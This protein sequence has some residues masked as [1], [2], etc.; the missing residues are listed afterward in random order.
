MSFSELKK[1]SKIQAKLCQFDHLFIA[2]LL[3]I[4][5]YI[6]HCSSRLLLAIF[7]LNYNH[8]STSSLTYTLLKNCSYCFTFHFI[9][10]FYSFLLF[11]IITPVEIWHITELRNKIYN[12]CLLI[13][14]SPIVLLNLEIHF[15]S[16]PYLVYLALGQHIA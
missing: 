15:D 7:F 6:L 11:E 3:L 13:K 2:S 10:N 8:L 4:L 9:H 16:F 12:S 1:A 5:E 14:I